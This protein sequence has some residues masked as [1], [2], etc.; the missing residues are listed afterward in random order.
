MTLRWVRV[1]ESGAKTGL[2][3]LLHLSAR[4]PSLPCVSPRVLSKVF[5]GS[6]TQHFIWG[7]SLCV[8]SS[9][10]SQFQWIAAGVEKFMKERSDDAILVFILLCP[11]PSCHNSQVSKWEGAAESW[12][13]QP[14]PAAL[15]DFSSVMSSTQFHLL[16]SVPAQ[17][18]SSS[19]ISPFSFHLYQLF[20][21]ILTVRS[22]LVMSCLTAEVKPKCHD[23]NCRKWK[24]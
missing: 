9:A 3:P 18:R 11:P 7:L 2:F 10:K 20:R 6:V 16:I 15:S 1:V 12:M 22:I 14:V 5:G 23:L 24:D 17:M 19:S 8:S 4:L 13:L 21:T